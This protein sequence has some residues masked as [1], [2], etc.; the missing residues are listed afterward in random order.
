MQKK[1][2]NEICTFLPKS[3]I[4]AGE[5]KEVGKYPFF[6]SS[7]IQKLYLDDFL[8]NGE[9][10]IIGTGGKPSCN[11]YSGK[12][13]V[14]TDNFV[15]KTNN[16][17]MGKYLYY[18]LRHNNL[19]VLE[20]GFRGAG[21][22][23]IG[24]EYLE[25]VLVPIKDLSIQQSIVATL[26]KIN[27]LIDA[28]KHHLEL[29]DEA[30]KSRFVEMF[31]N[32]NENNKGFE[33]NQLREFCDAIG[34]GLHGTP[35]YD[36]NGSYYFVNGNN[37]HKDKIKITDSTKKVGKTEYSKH[38]IAFNESTVFLSING[39][40]GNVAI[41]DNEPIIIGKSVAYCVLKGKLNKVF[42]SELFKSHFFKEYMESE[43][44]GST[45]KNFG[46]KALRDYRIIV[47]PLEMQKEFTEFVKQTEVMKNKII[48][49]IGY[50]ALLL[51]KKMD[52]Y[53]GGDANA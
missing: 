18:F 31:G 53:F 3:K 22:K 46:L 10:I 14:S 48:H 33:T 24:K 38:Y 15:L 43:S 28:N 39:T 19:A 4:R 23:H 51:N 27:E 2:I 34:D 50:L 7:D 13:A 5:G 37:L 20:K 49:N 16:K 21:L 47:P 25:S 17:V 11:Y 12:F 35:D 36:E 41:Y 8:H 45:I 29:L 1:T 6:T 32:I 44:S 42:V 9:R 40:L 52:E 26:D 30:V